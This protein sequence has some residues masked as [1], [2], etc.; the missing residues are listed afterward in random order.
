MREGACAAVVTRA[1]EI[2]SLMSIPAEGGKNG[3]L[4]VI[5]DSH[6]RPEHPLGAA[7]LL[8]HSPDDAATYLSKLFAVDASIMRDMN[9]QTQMLSHYSAH[10]MKARP[11]TE[12]EDIQAIYNANIKLLRTSSE[13]K[14]AIAREREVQVQVNTVRQ[15]LDNQ[16]EARR[17]ASMAESEASEK[18]RKLRK[19]LE[20][21]RE[22]ATSLSGSN[23][24]PTIWK[25][26]SGP[27]GDRRSDT[28]H[29]TDAKSKGKG[30][31]TDRNKSHA[32]SNKLQKP[33]PGKHQVNRAPYRIK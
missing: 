15:K 33:D 2:V 20:E 16:K 13:L 26:H 32:T 6:N 4:L 12:E 29:V 10:V 17:Q 21:A 31:D 18:L 27:I 7:F 24:T 14:E 25:G 8:F 19:E 30:V 22:L 1:P 28:S 11:F 23:S 5:F 9:W 3:N